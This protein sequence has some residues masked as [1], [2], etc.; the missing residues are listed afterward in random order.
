[1]NSHRRGSCPGIQDPVPTGDGL[2]AR[3]LP[4]APLSVDTVV[5][6]CEA[7][8]THG[9]GIVEITQRGSLQ[10]RGLSCASA[11]KFAHSVVALG[12]GAQSGPP[13][14]AS[15]LMGLDAQESLDLR[16]QLAV[17]RTALRN[18]PTLT[19]I[20]PKVSVLVDGGGAVHL[21]G[22]PGDLRLRAGA[23]SR[24]HLSIAGTAA[25][26]TH[27]GWVAA[28]HAAEVIARLLAR[29][30]DRGP[31]ARGRDFTNPADLR[32]LRGSLSN[33]LSDAP[34]PTPRLPA[35]PIG[36]HP[37][38]TGKM[39]LG[40]AVAFGYAEAAVLQRLAQRAAG[41][42][43]T[44]IQPSP[45]RSLLLIGLEADGADELTAAAADAGAGA[46]FIVRPDDPRRFVV[47]CAGA[48]ACDSAMLSTRE[49]APAIAEAAKPFLDGSL[50]IHVSGCA[51]GCAHPGT[52]AL[53]FIG[54]NR[55]VIQGRAGDA[56]H[57]T[58]SITEFIAGVARLS[59]KRQQQP[60][61]DRSVDI[62][63][64][65]GAAGVLAAMSAGT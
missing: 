27:L 33:M 48:P 9:N 38:N 64:K 50:T 24:L 32:A 5:A 23:N 57:G 65:L 11:P 61:Q 45:G 62:V 54:P 2:L 53:T 59:A 8:Q 58:T 1:V 44:S 36:L 20:G 26:S 55:L 4:T 21:D 7:S 49:L 46:G 18:D 17:L 19:S 39:A 47:A 60:A 12:L 35:E 40:V 30:A 41:C 37:L 6:L 42:G 31:D 15:P 29:I 52:A 43:A 16:A 25:T 10:F 28:D 22:V 51:K 63:S 3:L 56:P 14:L 13:I 34:P